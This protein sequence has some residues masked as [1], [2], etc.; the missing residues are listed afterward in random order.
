MD[1][2]GALSSFPP[3]ATAWDPSRSKLL[4][5]MPGVPVYEELVRAG[6]AGDAIRAHEGKHVAALHC[7]ACVSP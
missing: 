6:G 5:E 2:A 1:G 3:V 7:R 4:R